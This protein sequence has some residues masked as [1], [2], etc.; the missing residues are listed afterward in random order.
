MLISNQPF[1]HALGGASNTFTYGSLGPID[2]STSSSDQ[3]LNGS[4]GNDTI[5][6]GSGADTITSGTGTDSIY[7]QNGDD[8]ITIDG[9][10]NKTI[11]GGAGTDALT[12]SYT[13]ITNLGDFEVSTSGDYT[14]LTDASDNV[15][16]FKNI[17]NLTV[18]SVA[19]TNDVGSKTYY[20]T[21]E[22]AVYLYLGGN[23]SSG[24]PAFMA[25][26]NNTDNWSI[27]GSGLADTLSLNLPRTP[28][29]GSSP[30]NIGGLL[31]VNLGD[32]DDA[33]NSGRLANGDSIDMGS[34]NDIVSLMFG[35]SG[36]PQTFI[37][38]NLT[39]LDGSTGEDTLSFA[40][41]DN[42]GGATLSLTT[43]GATNFENLVGSNN[44]EI[45]NGDANSNK[46]YGSLGCN[47]D[48]N[49]INGNDG[50]D[51]LL[52][53]DSTDGGTDRDW[54]VTPSSGNDLSASLNFMTKFYDTG[55][56]TLNGGTGN[57]VLIGAK[58]EDTLDGGAGRDHMTGG[59]G[60]D[61]F[62]IRE[63]DGSSS[64]DDADIIYDFGSGDKIGM[65]GIEYSQLTVEQGTGDYANHVIVKKDSEFLVII[66]NISISSISNTDFSAI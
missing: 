18:A 57:D 47:G 64:L 50:N 58:G 10:G 1:T 63:G 45:I 34:G 17:E 35:S 16:Q 2:F 42:T 28:G 13:G 44:P 11:D 15:I 40:E 52:A 21:S 62:V 25:M 19:Y 20:S 26:Y 7:A 4:A 37:D 31:T 5:I 53:C 54:L 60:I 24:H 14:V 61:V 36:Y 33:I 56:Q 22:D 27:T 39:K 29:D 41:S 59:A 32:G 51:F 12:I 38:A 30:S 46:L 9:A 65:D 23:M 48:A 66:Q 55:N 49:T 8:T 6:G 3:T 43:G